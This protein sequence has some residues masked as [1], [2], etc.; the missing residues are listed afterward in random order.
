MI[1]S[2]VRFFSATLP[3]RLSYQADPPLAMANTFNHVPSQDTLTRGADRHSLQP[4]PGCVLAQ[5]LRDASCS[6]AGDASHLH[7][8]RITPR[9]SDTSSTRL[10]QAPSAA[11][12]LC[13]GGAGSSVCG[14]DPDRHSLQPLPGCVLA[15]GLRDASCSSAGDASHLHVYRITPRMSDASWDCD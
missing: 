11:P 10:S 15:R 14:E 3:R 5:G 9:M 8:Y 4:L 2:L 12:S 1:H 7:V 13:S 6:S